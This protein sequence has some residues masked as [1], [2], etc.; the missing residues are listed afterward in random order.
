AMRVQATE[1][2]SRVS[3]ARMA[4]VG[5]MGDASGDGV[6]ALE[7]IAPT[8][9]VPAVPLERFFDWREIPVYIGDEPP[10]VKK[11]K[12]SSNAHI[13][14]FDRAGVP[15]PPDLSKYP[16][17]LVLILAPLTPCQTEVALYGEECDPW[18]T[19]P[20]HFQWA[21]INLS[22]KFCLGADLN[23]A[24]FRDAMPCLTTKSV[25]LMRVLTEDGAR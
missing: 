19:V 20:G 4:L 2:G 25:L 12:G 22:L 14:Y 8:L 24:V 11:M 6:R 7:A 15:Y 10:K 9:K 23:G 16:V 3:R 18:P 17:E 21:D 5:L 13:E 1:Y